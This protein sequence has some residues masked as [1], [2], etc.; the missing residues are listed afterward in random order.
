MILEHKLIAFK[1]GFH[2]KASSMVLPSCQES[3][4]IHYIPS[5]NKDIFSINR[6]PYIQQMPP[7]REHLLYYLNYILSTI[8]RI[9]Q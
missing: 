1:R 6:K 2:L 8:S 5:Q 7:K 3:L 4:K 9:L